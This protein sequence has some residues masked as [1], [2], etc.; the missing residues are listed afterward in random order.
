MLVDGVQ[1]V[2]AL[3]IEAEDEAEEAPH[4]KTEAFEEPHG[5]GEEELPPKTELL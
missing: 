3:K 5:D 2:A 4:S 1:E